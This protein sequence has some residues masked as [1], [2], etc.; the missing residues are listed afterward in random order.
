MDL[1]EYNRNNLYPFNSLISNDP[2]VV[3]LVKEYREAARNDYYK[4]KS[5]NFMYVYMITVLTFLAVSSGAFPMYKDIE[6]PWWQIWLEPLLLWIPYVF[7]SHYLAISN[8]VDPEKEPEKDNKV[9]NALILSILPI[10]VL[11]TAKAFFAIGVLAVSVF[12]F[13]DCATIAKKARRAYDARIKLC[14]YVKSKEPRLNYF[15]ETWYEDDFNE[16]FNESVEYILKKRFWGKRISNLEGFYFQVP[17]DIKSVEKRLLE[18]EKTP[19]AVLNYLNKKITIVNVYQ[20]I[21]NLARASL[22]KDMEDLGLWFNY[23]GDYLFFSSLS[24]I[25]KESLT[26]EKVAMLLNQISLLVIYKTAAI[27][28]KEENGSIDET[29]LLLFEQE[30]DIL[31]DMVKHIKYESNMK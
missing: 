13:I 27:L 6:L 19:Q 14:D 30:V 20:P 25:S 18:N 3:R 26:D 10:L 1:V 15:N 21:E 29:L 2:D 12:V 7:L 22:E 17:L 23:F 24:E 28:H 4:Y 8:V 5:K 16:Q 11:V 31:G 9:K